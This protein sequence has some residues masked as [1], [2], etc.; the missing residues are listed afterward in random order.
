MN[1]DAGT[2]TGCSLGNPTT[3]GAMTGGTGT[4]GTIRKN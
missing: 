4:Y 1:F 3:R 2:L